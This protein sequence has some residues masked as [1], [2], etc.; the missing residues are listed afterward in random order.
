[1]TSFPYVGFFNDEITGA[2]AV[3]YQG[4]NHLLTVGPPGTGKSSGLHIPNL[5][6]LNRSIL[7][8]DPKGELAA[9][10]AQHRAKF[11]RVVVLNPFGV[12][13]DR[14]PFMRSNGYNPLSVLDH[15]SPNF[16]D[17]A[18]ALARGI[19]K[20]EGNEP[21]WSRGGQTFVS[22]LIM[23]ICKTQGAAANLGSL[24]ELL[25][26][27]RGHYIENGA[28]IPT[29]LDKT[30]IEMLS[31]DFPA[32]RQK[33]GKFKKD[34]QEIASIISAAEGQCDFLDSPPIVQDLSSTNHLNFSDMRRNIVT[35]Y[36]V[37]P[38]DQM[39]T[40]SNWLR[41]VVASALNSLSNFSDVAG[42]SRVMF[43][44]DEFANLGYMEDIETAMAAARG[45]R[46]Q[47]WPCV[48]CVGQ[49]QTLYGNNWEI[50]LGGAG[51][52]NYFTPRTMI[53]A[54]YISRRCGEQEV[55]KTTRNTDHQGKTGRGFHSQKEPLY[56]PTRLMGLPVRQ[57]IAFREYLDNPMFFE[58]PHYRDQR[59][60]WCRSLP[61][62]P[63][64]VAALPYGRAQLVS[65]IGKRL[66]SRP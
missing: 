58:V 30:I 25:T 26:Q 43:M 31:S 18:K 59:L 54:E 53:T 56:S 22:A 14:L 65:T 34:N 42:G 21:H 29:G 2:R 10:T 12:L 39:K 3:T 17:N 51:F 24:R 36:L 1:M 28:P 35:I 23:H 57:T 5:A 7:A 40:H 46:I 62:P 4:D 11:G 44:L 27:T 66:R 48:Q 32:I 8:I 13:V 50:F 45:F 52:H 61:P 15:T 41:L 60:T 55:T 64:D 37:L 63:D 33:A 6:L 19:V 16:V 20:V 47:L 38:F 49:L 9:T